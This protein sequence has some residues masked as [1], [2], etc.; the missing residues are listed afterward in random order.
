M[1]I[2]K[3]KKLVS[4][5]KSETV[6]GSDVSL[7]TKMIPL[8]LEERT[9]TPEE[10]YDGFSEVTVQGL[11]GYVEVIDTAGTSISIA[12]IVIENNIVKIIIE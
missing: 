9:I 4:F 6:E 10:G 11:D 12:E 1:K 2:Y 7:Q 5:L 3:G 8:A